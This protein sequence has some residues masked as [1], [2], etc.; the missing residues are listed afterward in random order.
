MRIVR[1]LAADGPRIGLVQSDRVVDLLSAAQARVLIG[2]AR[3]WSI[4][5]S[6]L[7]AERNLREMIETLHAILGSHGSRPINDVRVLAPF[8]AGAKVLAHVVNYFEHGAEANLKA[9]EKPFFFYKPP[10]VGF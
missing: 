4:Y 7:L 5:V 10:Y 1:F 3:F 9:P 8:E 6:F 2:C